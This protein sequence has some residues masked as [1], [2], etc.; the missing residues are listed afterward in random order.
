MLPHGA[1]EGDLSVSPSSG[2]PSVMY[3]RTGELGP[4]RLTPARAAAAFW[5]VITVRVAL[6]GREANQLESVCAVKG[7]L[8][9]KPGH[10]VA[11]LLCHPST[12]GPL[13]Q[14][15]VTVWRSLMEMGFGFGLR[16]YMP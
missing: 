2:D 10:G 7:H 3:R 16:F 6:V 9:D 8:C 11:C 4:A 5:W 12:W 13:L 14:R 1:H 15:R